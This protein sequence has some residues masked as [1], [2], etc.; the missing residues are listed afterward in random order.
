MPGVTLLVGTTKGAFVLTGDVTRAGW[1]VSGPHCDG[2]PIEI[3]SVSLDVWLV[4][5]Q[6]SA[7]SEIRPAGAATLAMT[8]LRVVV[9]R[10]PSGRMASLMWITS[11]I[12]LPV[13]STVI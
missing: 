12:T 1:Q 13:R 9:G 8:K 6:A 4:K 5:G 10:A 7:S 11:P 2:W 3:F